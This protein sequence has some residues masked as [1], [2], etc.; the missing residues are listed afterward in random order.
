MF[1][2]IIKKT[3]TAVIVATLALLTVFSVDA[4]ASTGS[5][6][7]TVKAMGIIEADKG[8][9]ENISRAELAQMLV[10]ASGYADTVGNGYGY[11]LYSDVKADH[12]Q[13]AYIKIAIEEG[14]LTGYID[15]T[16]RPDQNISLEEAITAIL[17]LLGYDS[18]QLVGSFPSAQLS[19]AD[20]LGLMDGLNSAQGQLINT[21]QIATIFYNAMLAK[22]SEGAVYGTSLGYN[23]SND[24]IDYNSLVD[25]GTAGPFVVNGA[26]NVPFD[27]SNANIYRDGKLINASQIV[28]NDVYYY[29]SSMNTVWL[30]TDQEWGTITALSPSAAAPTAVTVAGNSYQIG[31][32]DAAYKLS[33]QGSFSIGDS[34]IL[35]LGMNGEVVDILDAANSNSYYYG[36]V[37]SSEVQSDLALEQIYYAT[38]IMATDGSERTF[39]H[40]GYAK[41]EGSLVQVSINEQGIA[42]NNV[43]QR[44]LSGTVN[45]EATAIGDYQFA[46][47]IQ[48]L[49]TDGADGFSSIYPQRLANAT[50]SGS[51]IIYYQL[52]AQNQ[53]SHLIIENV[54][55]DAA[56]YAYISATEKFSKSDGAASSSSSYDTIINGSSNQ[57][58]FNG[59]IYSAEKGGAQL[60]YDNDQVDGI[61]NISEANID[62]ISGQIAFSDDKQYQISE[63]VQVLIEDD[64]EYSAATLAEINGE[65][66]HLSAWYDHNQAPAGGL[67][68]IIIAEP[69]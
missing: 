8:S 53:I 15:G 56:T 44:S 1:K 23:I 26:L 54:T 7:E 16:F 4:Q 34:V 33:S 52:N 38:T 40:S 22:T 45:A 58:K 48:I 68:R 42:I 67:I 11:S 5:N 3:L 14:W 66:Y 28:N 21:E 10:Q 13:A 63:F 69:K 36:L 31:T 65:D 9:G 61:T 24:S 17:K 59:I 57:L 43:N 12:P 2:S 46:A 50:L 32:A 27:L 51:D 39:I 18:S 55:G 6:L 37:K 60:K 29:N 49:E 19:K 64:G 41:T 25:N 20:S 35:L 62:S 30:Y 47:N